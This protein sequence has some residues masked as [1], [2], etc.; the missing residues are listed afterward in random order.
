MRHFSKKLVILVSLALA[1][2]GCDEEDIFTEQQAEE[3]TSIALMTYFAGS[4]FATF[5]LGGQ[6]GDFDILADCENGG[7]TRFSGSIA[8]ANE[9]EAAIVMDADAIDCGDA[10]T[11]IDG[12]LHF[13]GTT[14]SFDISG[15]YTFSGDTL[16]GLCSFELSAEVSADGE[17]VDVIGTACG[18]D[19]SGL[20]TM[21]ELVE[22]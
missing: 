19:V 5:E 9:T 8:I 16:S 3:A 22:A 2:A 15:S 11:T 12:A 6:P 7:T 14:E 20:Y 21:D 1:A 10:M 17:S 13:E 4:L 18:Q